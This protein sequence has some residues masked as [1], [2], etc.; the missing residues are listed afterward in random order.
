ML[1]QSRSVNIVPDI[2]A[3]EYIQINVVAIWIGKWLTAHCRSRSSNGHFA[4]ALISDIDLEQLLDTWPKNMK[5]CY[6]ANSDIHLT[7]LTIL[8]LQCKH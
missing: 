8:K 5:Y 7:T 1:L 4:A 2:G 6:Q 3:P